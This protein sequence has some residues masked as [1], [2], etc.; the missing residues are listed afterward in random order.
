MYGLSESWVLFWM[1][2]IVIGSWLSNVFIFMPD[3][4]PEKQLLWGLG[5]GFFLAWVIF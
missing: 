3:G 2:F 1:G 4:D 5:V